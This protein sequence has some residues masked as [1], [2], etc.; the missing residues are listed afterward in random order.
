MTDRDLAQAL[1][2][3]VESEHSARAYWGSTTDVA[4]RDSALIVVRHVTALRKSLETWIGL[5]ACRAQMGK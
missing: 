4:E 3:A 2:R 5:R 1:T